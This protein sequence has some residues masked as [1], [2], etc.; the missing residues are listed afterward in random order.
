MKV[1]PV[2]GTPTIPQSNNTGVTP[3]KLIRLKAIASG[4]KPD[5]K[6]E[7]IGAVATS[8]SDV[9][10]IKMQ[11]NRNMYR[12]GDSPVEVAP[13]AEENAISD[14][15]VQVNAEPEATGQLSPQF[16][17]LARQRRALQVKERELSDKMKALEGPTRGDLESRIK[18]QPL[19]V[20]QELGVT[21]EQ[22]TNE[23][24]ASQG[25]PQIDPEKLK[26]EIT[27]DFEKKF[28]EKE[29]QQEQAVLAEMRRNVDSMV[30]T[31]D[32]F[33]LIRAGGKQS[34]VVELIH[35]TWKKTGQVLDEAEAAKLVEDEL[36]EEHL[37]SASLKKVQGRL[38]PPPAEVTA[39]VPQGMKTLTNRDQ[40]KPLMNRR[41][42]AIAAALGQKH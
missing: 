42:R 19:S 22:L 10:R 27:A 36:L 5:E 32:D 28:V 4:E 38:T 2:T 41:Q 18:S 26:A 34:D 35:R 29:Q 1:T 16:A 13:A 37:K 12:D 31:G 25:N 23:I 11:T 39:P 7:N 40:A 3:E 30:A 6:L 9:P 24:L 33:E 20:L 17:A 14:A 21:Y 15:S 8:G